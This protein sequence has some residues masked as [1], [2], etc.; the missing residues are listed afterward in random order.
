MD[1]FLGLDAGGTKTHCLIGDDQGNIVGFGRAGTGNY[2]I[3]GVGP[4]LDE[5]RKAV[6]A[7]LADAGLALGHISAIGM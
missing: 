2:E 3:H 6:N 7:A 1:H 4:A 5:N